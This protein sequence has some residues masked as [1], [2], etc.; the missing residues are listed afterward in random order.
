ML[1]CEKC[2]LSKI[3]SKLGFVYDKPLFSFKHITKNKNFNFDSKSI[4]EKELKK[5]HASLNKKIIDIET[6]FTVKYLF[7]LRNKEIF[8][9]FCINKIKFKPNEI[10]VS[11]DTKIYIFRVTSKYRMICLYS[12]IAPVFHVIGFDFRFNAYNH[13]S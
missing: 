11:D 5:F 12:D 9:S 2:N 13:G 4:D 6:N 7:S 10:T 1:L 3:K 8:E